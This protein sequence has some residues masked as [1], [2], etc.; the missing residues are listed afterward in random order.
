MRYLYSLDIETDYEEQ[1]LQC[2]AFSFDGITIYSVPILDFNYRWAYSSAH[3]ILRALA[4]AIRDNIL[5][6]HNGA[7][8]DFFVLA[9]KYKIVINNTC[10]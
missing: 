2:F 5:V 9:F 1:N 6:A 7:S 3:L 4:V 8:F 10:Y